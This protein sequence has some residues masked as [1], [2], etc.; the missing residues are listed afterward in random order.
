MI[1]PSD[2]PPEFGEGLMLAAMLTVTLIMF[3]AVFAGPIWPM[4]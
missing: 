4:L 1:D 3:G 2:P